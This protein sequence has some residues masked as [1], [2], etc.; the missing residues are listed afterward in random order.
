[1]RK[2]DD[3]KSASLMLKF[4]SPCNLRWTHYLLLLKIDNEAERDFFEIESAN[5]N[6]SVRELDKQYDS[7]IYER[8][9]LSRDK[10]AMKELSRK[11]QLISKPSDT[12]KEPYVLDFTGFEEN[13]KYKEADFES[14]II[15]KLEHFLTELGKGFCLLADNKE[16][17]LKMSISMLIWF[18]IIDCFNV[19]C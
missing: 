18:S 15:N 17:Q 14:A 13:D 8:L 16:L 9:A 10:E 11:G 7:S 3:E 4:E 1:M 19:L 5:N 12:I 6:W 2:S